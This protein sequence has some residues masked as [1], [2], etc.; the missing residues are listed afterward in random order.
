LKKQLSESA[1][2]ECQHRTVVRLEDIVQN[3]PLSNDDHIIRE[4]HDILKSYYK[5]SRKR[6]VDNVRMQAA[7]FYLLAGPKTPLKLFYPKFVAGLTTAQLED[8]A[9]E[10]LGMKRKR[11]KLEKEIELLEE[12]MRILR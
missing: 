2:S 5:L 7:D 8:I 10:E 4:I 1:F 3:H 6:L 12:G 11:T 9:G